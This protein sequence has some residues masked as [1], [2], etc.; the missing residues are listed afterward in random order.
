MVEK[1][2]HKRLDCAE[3]C[4]LFHDHSKYSG[5]IMNISITGA[6]VDLPGLTFGTLKPG[7]TCTLILSNDPDDYYCSYKGRITRIIPRGVGLEILEHDF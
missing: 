6:L 2:L 5:A 1:R 7:D 3:K 4:F